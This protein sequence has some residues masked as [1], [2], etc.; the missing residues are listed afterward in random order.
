MKV[1]EVHKRTHIS[2][3]YMESDAKVG[4]M[5]DQNKVHFEKSESLLIAGKSLESL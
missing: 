3:E 1:R 4:H 5:K 2:N